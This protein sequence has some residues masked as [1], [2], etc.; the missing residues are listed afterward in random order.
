MVGFFFNIKN[1]NMSKLSRYSVRSTSEVRKH[2]D[3]IVTNFMGGNSYKL[4][5]LQTLKIIAAS[6]I[7]AEPQ[8]YRDGLNSEKY[9]KNHSMI[10]KYSIFPDLFKDKRS[11]VEVFSSS[12]D[13]SLD[14]NFKAT[15]DL[16]KELRSVYYMRL[17]PS[18]IFIRASIHPKRI[19]FNEKNPGY[20]KSIG[21]AISFRPDDLTNQFDYFMF[22]NKS[23]NKLSSIVKRTWAEK[24]EEFSKYQLNKYK[25]KKLIDLV[26]ISHAWNSDIDELMK[27]GTLKI[28]DNEQTWEM[29]ISKNGSNKESWEWVI[30]NLWLIEKQ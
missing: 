28:D 4:D 15:L 13:S 8:Y 12:I 22:L 3:K 11:A 24:L 5:P 20:M 26:R 14:Y 7:F 18:V 17:N 1:K 27:T 10:L 23:K 21:K 29:Y 30:D 19:E 9:I 2:E 25:G 6:S 16:A